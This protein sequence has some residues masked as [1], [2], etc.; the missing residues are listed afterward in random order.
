[1]RITSFWVVTKPNQQSTLPDILFEADP[2]RL[3][4]QFLGGL[5]PGDIAGVFTEHGEAEALAQWLLGNIEVWLGESASCEELR[6]KHIRSISYRD[7]LIEEAHA[8]QDRWVVRDGDGVEH[9]RGSLRE[10]REAIDEVM[11]EVEEEQP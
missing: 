9:F 8:A 3:R 11:D 1:M 7:H 2:A 6:A 10:C 5:D 4:L